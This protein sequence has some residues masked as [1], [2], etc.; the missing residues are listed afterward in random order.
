MDV[1]SK[2]TQDYYKIYLSMF[3][4]EIKMV[5]IYIIYNKHLGGITCVVKF[6]ELH[7][8]GLKFYIH[9]DEVM[10]G[11]AWTSHVVRPTTTSHTH[12][13]QRTYVIMSVFV[14]HEDEV[15]GGTPPSTPTQ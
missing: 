13:R 8:K 14:L 7:A 11:L 4:L 3:L 2:L 1:L 10:T 12:E 6:F 15:E 5:L 9:L